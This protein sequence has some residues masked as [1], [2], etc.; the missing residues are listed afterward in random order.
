MKTKMSKEEFFELNYTAC[1]NLKT[2][3]KHVRG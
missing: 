1:K 2:A 3:F